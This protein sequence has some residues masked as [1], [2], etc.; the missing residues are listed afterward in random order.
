MPVTVTLAAV[1]LQTEEVSAA[2]NDLEA[3]G[4]EMVI[5]DYGGS[6]EVGRALE[7]PDGEY[8]EMEENGDYHFFSW[9]TDREAREIAGLV[10]DILGQ[11]TREDGMVAIAL[12]SGEVETIEGPSSELVQLAREESHKITYVRLAMGGDATL[13]WREPFK[14]SRSSIEPRATISLFGS[15][16]NSESLERVMGRTATSV[17]AKMPRQFIARIIAHS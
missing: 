3:G 10:L 8:L 14:R 7:L 5:Q 1:G 2:L 4:I 11:P 12:D 17:I 13:N 6:G 16:L 15:K 9:T